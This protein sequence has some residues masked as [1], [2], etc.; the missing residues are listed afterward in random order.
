VDKDKKI[1]CEGKTRINLRSLR[2]APQLLLLLFLLLLPS[3]GFGCDFNLNGSERPWSNK[4]Q[5]PQISSYRMTLSS[6]NWQ[7]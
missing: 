4:I 2:A 5:V 7:N 6:S 1:K 3:L